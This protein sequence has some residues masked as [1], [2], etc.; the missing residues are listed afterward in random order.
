MCIYI[1]ITDI[2]MSDYAQVNTWFSICS[3]LHTCAGIY[4]YICMSPSKDN[5]QNSIGLL[6]PCSGCGRSVGFTG[7]A[8][9]QHGPDARSDGTP[10]GPWDCTPRNVVSSHLEGK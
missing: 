10:L 4:I 7:Y 2:Y 1:Y 6:V 5:A 9:L 8:S 3:S